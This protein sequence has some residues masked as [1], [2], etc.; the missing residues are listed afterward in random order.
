LQ[1]QGQSKELTMGKK[2]LESYMKSSSCLVCKGKLELEGAICLKC[3]VD[4][5]ASLLSLR[6][7]VNRAERRLLD[8]QK[9][10][11]SCS[12]ISPLDEVKCDSKDCPVFYTRTRQK[13]LLKT[14]KV[15]EPVMKELSDAIVHTDDL[16]W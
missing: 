3:L 8:L 7:R 15:V 14:E 16:D 2:T 5:P 13:A 9:V 4:K 10:C 6:S 12:G 11:Q 1:L